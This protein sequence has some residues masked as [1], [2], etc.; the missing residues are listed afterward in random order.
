M[1]GKWRELWRP[2]RKRHMMP[3]WWWQFVP[4]LHVTAKNDRT[5]LEATP[6][7]LVI[8]YVYRSSRYYPELDNMDLLYGRGW[9][10]DDK[11]T[12]VRNRGWGICEWKQGWQH[13]LGGITSALPITFFWID[14][15]SRPLQDMLIWHTMHASKQRQRTMVCP[16]WPW[17][18]KPTPANL[19]FPGE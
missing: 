13:L 12:G 15:R 10:F 19:L 6:F 11:H 8:P 2:Q 16:Y 4:F 17:I 3:K 5:S 7:V 18:T 1:N 14:A 9:A